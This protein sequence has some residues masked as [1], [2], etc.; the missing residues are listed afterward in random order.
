[1]ATLLT[2]V[3]RWNLDQGCLHEGFG[4]GVDVLMTFGRQLKVFGTSVIGV[5]CCADIPR[6]PQQH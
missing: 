6:S 2:K 3:S 5:C 1:M 4:K